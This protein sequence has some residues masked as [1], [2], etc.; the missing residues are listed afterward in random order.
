MIDTGC[1][2][3][4][5]ISNSP[6]QSSLQFLLSCA[7]ACRECSGVKELPIEKPKERNTTEQV[8][9]KTQ[10]KQQAPTMGVLVVLLNPIVPGKVVVKN[11]AGK[12][13]KE[14]DAD[15]E[16]QAEFL[17]RRNEQYE[18]EATSPGYSSGVATSKTL[19]GQTI[20]RVQLNAQSRVLRLASMPP[21]AEVVIDKKAVVSEMVGGIAT[22]AGVTPTKHSILVR[23]PE[24]NDFTADID[25][26][27][28]GLGEAAYADCDARACFEAVD[29]LESGSDNSD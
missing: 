9:V 6:K 8:K 23:H 1:R 29:Q 4:E 2:Q 18:V 15:R 21:G 16:G 26:S 11:K 14:L 20:V 3:L 13:L 25:F 17:L 19:T 24:Y 27:R 12:V 10:P 7:S 22:V 5:Q 28:V